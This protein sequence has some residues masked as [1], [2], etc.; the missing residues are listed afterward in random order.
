MKK[1]TGTFRF[2]Q[3]LMGALIFS[4]L[5]INLTAP[6]DI[7]AQGMDGSPY[8]P[9]VDTNIDM[10]IGSWLNS[11]PRHSH[12]SL[13]ERDILTKG[14]P[15]NPPY[16]G[17]VLRFANKLAYATLDAGASTSPTILKEEQEIF[18][19]N[20]GVGIISAGGETANLFKG[21]TVLIPEGLEFTMTNTG[22]EPL[23]MYLISDPT[24][25][26]AKPNDKMK[27]RDENKIPYAGST[28]HWCHLPKVLFT[29]ADGLSSID[30]VLT[31][32]LDPMTIAQPHY[33]GANTEEVWVM[34]DGCSILFLGKQIRLQ[35]EG[36]GFKVPSDGKTNH[37]NINT[38]SERIKM[39][40]FAK[41]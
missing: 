24:K 39:F 28:G 20:K 26:N 32:S 30:N 34:V 18:Y 4:T 37:S 21:I 2:V 38:S 29:K 25:P 8:K 5:F 40:Y 17:A 7:Y 36:T 1:N 15:L 13:V 33:H 11:M 12:G 35:P 6:S 19:I 31:V 16:Q 27:V 9:G 23:I 41:Y 14:D 10:Y 22:K 3:K